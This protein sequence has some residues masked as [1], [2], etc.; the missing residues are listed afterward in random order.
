[1]KKIILFFLL[2]ICGKI[3]AQ[4]YFTDT[5]NVVTYNVNNYGFASTGSCPLT[6]SPLKHQYL[7]TVVKYAAPDIIAF[8]K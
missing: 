6:G 4:P 5:V 1:M 3:L 8:K 2:C 7:R